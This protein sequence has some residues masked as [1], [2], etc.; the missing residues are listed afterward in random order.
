TQPESKEALGR[1]FSAEAVDMESYWIGRAAQA[2]GVRFLTVRAI[3]D[4]VG[5]HL[6]SLEQLFADSGELRKGKAAIYFL[7][8]PWQVAKLFMLGRSARRAE[9]NLALF[10]DGLIA[11]F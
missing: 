7:T 3:T 2:R 9:K 11:Q 6:P 10:L 8:H 1:E 4:T 5:E